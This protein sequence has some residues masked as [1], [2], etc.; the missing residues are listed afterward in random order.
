MAFHVKPIRRYHF[1]PLRYPGG[2]TRPIG[3]ARTNIHQKLFRKI[4]NPLLLNDNQMRTGIMLLFNGKAQHNLNGLEVIHL[5]LPFP[6]KTTLNLFVTFPRGK[7][8]DRF[9]TLR[10]LLR[11]PNYTG[12]NSGKQE[13][14]WICLKVKIPGRTNWKDVSY[15]QDI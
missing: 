5:S 15:Y 14:L 9:L 10:K 1:S 12:K 13:V 3:I 6:T 8:R 2:K 4:T 7:I 11:K